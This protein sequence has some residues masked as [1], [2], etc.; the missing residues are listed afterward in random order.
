[1][2]TDDV[3]L[4]LARRQKQIEYGKNTACYAKYVQD[5]QRLVAVCLHAILA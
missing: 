1:L 3:K 5:V 2:E 4:I